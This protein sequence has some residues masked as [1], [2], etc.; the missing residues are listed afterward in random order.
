MTSD[1]PAAVILMSGATPVIAIAVTAG[2]DLAARRRN[3]RALESRARLSAT[4]S[5]LTGPMHDEVY[6]TPA[7]WDR[8]F[9]ALVK[10]H[11][12][13]DWTYHQDHDLEEPITFY[14]S[15][16]EMQRWCLDCGVSIDAEA[17]ERR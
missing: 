4:P 2:F 13:R 16:Y 17:G 6:Q 5:A 14:A 7:W 3:H 10:K 1:W 9:D 8:E 11:I 12:P 15:G